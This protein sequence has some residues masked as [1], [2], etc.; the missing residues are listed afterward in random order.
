VVVG[1][2]L[3]FNRH[4]QAADYPATD[5][6]SF[7]MPLQ[8]A[9][10]FRPLTRTMIERLGQWDRGG[11]FARTREDWLARACGIGEAIRV[12]L[13]ERELAGRFEAV[14]T[15]GR[16]VLRLVDG[17]AETVTAGDVF[18]LARTAPHSVGETT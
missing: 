8:P 11:G 18:P 4:P 12:V 1:M 14:D 5:L 17:R 6:A 9:D 13:A 16:L 15:A 7:G 10:V 3:N 2:G